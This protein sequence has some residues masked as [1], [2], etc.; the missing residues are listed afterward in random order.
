MTVSGFVA[1]IQAVGQGPPWLPFK[2]RWL[3]WNVALAVSIYKDVNAQ[4]AMIA[5]NLMPKVQLLLDWERYRYYKAH[6]SGWNYLPVS[7]YGSD[8]MLIVLT[9]DTCWISAQQ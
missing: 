1:R 5:T 7:C 4:I 8:S 3:K 9:Q 2:D 6:M